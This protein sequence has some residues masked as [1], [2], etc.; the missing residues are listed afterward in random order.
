MIDLY[1]YFSE[2]LFQFF[3]VLFSIIYVVFSIKQNIL[4]WPALIFGSIFNMLA[5]YQI[6]L[7][8]QLIMQF[9]FIGT[10]VIGWLNWNKIGEENMLKINRIAL[11]KHILWI[12]L[13]LLTTV[14]LT[15]ALKNYNLSVFPFFD[16]L[17]FC[18][19]IIPMYMIG[20]KILESWIY[21]IV[22]DIISGAFYLQTGEY[23]F[24]L[25][26]FCYIGFA[27]KGYL[28]WKQELK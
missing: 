4:C 8:L 7:N 13:G 18:F 5:Y 20:K 1:S 9:F 23:F 26:F 27:F 2:N 15:V 14:V 22:I 16:S 12:F 6:N 28:S 17:M 19:N 10:G 11:N 24:C 3:G 25:L 21:F